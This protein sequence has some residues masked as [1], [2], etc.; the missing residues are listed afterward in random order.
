MTSELAQLA[1]STANP[2]ASAGPTIQSDLVTYVSN[3]VGDPSFISAFSKLDP[4]LPDDVK[5]QAEGDP[6]SFAFGLITAAT[7]PAWVNAIP[8]DIVDYIQSV[9]E[10][11]DSIISKDLTIPP[12]PL[13]TPATRTTLESRP[14]GSLS[15][16][17]IT[18]QTVLA[19]STASTVSPASIVT[20]APAGSGVRPSGS[21][22]SG[23]SSGSGTNRI[24]TTPSSPTVSQFVPGSAAASRWNSMIGTVAALMAV[25][26]GAL[27]LA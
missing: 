1:S 20:T 6:T 19:T 23:G 8:T 2:I 10:D 25:G 7:P 5:T 15:G 9:G 14:G 18:R 26:V 22:G 21:I 12:L 16:I 17:P 13:P 11:V 24:V 27:L 4:F 3:L